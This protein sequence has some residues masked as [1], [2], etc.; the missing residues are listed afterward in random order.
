MKSLKSIVLGSIGGLVGGFT[1]LLWL[2][3][4]PDTLTDELNEIRSDIKALEESK[5]TEDDA[6]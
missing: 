4:R 3:S 5:K 2:W 6:E 1:V